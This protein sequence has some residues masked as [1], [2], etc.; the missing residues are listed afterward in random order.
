[1]SVP[2]GC[3]ASP[4]CGNAAPGELVR[5]TSEFLPERE[6]PTSILRKFSPDVTSQYS[7]S[8]PA[9]IGTHLGGSDP[10]TPRQTIH[11]LALRLPRDG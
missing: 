8:Y 9:A 4:G 2:T 1:V 10:G 7:P 6:P 11:M 3:A 5:A